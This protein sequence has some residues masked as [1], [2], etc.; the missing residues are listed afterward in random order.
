MP[1]LHA[2][3]S[4]TPI[5][6]AN[7]AFDLG[8]HGKMD[9]MALVNQPERA[10]ERA[11]RTESEGKIGDVVE[12]PQG[13]AA[14]CSVCIVPTLVE[15]GGAEGRPHGRAPACDGLLR[16]GRFLLL[17]TRPVAALRIPGQIQRKS[18][19]SPARLIY[20]RA[21][22]LHAKAHR[23]KVH[24]DHRGWTDRDRPGLRIRLFRNASL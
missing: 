3:K 23:H 1:I 21:T 14:C 13:G 17:S 19:C 18:C 7:V 16:P 4:L 2:V 11:K 20:K 24:P 22:V 10:L 6:R 12:C 9:G 15:I 8:G 5:P